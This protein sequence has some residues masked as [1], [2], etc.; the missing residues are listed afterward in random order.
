MEYFIV[1]M[2]SVL[3]VVA[4]IILFNLGDGV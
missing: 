1:A 2:A 4:L 3:L